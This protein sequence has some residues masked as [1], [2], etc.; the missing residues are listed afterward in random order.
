MKG[1]RSQKN[2]IITHK[3]YK[4]ALSANDNIITREVNKIALSANDDK[5]VIQ[6]DLVLL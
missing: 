3:V 5:C 1:N 2:N 4:I 6:S